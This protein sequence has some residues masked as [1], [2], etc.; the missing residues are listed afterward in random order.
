VGGV[1]LG[2]IIYH[3]CHTGGLYILRDARLL[4]SPPAAFNDPF[5]LSPKYVRIEPLTDEWGAEMLGEHFDEYYERI[6]RFHGRSKEEER[7]YCFTNM[8]KIVEELRAK[9]PE[10]ANNI[11]EDFLQHSSNIWTLGCFSKTARSVLMWSHYAKKHT[12]MVIGFDTNHKPFNMPGFLDLIHVKYRKERPIFIHGRSMETFEKSLRRV[13][14]TKSK[15]WSYEREVRVLVPRSAL[16]EGKY[17]DLIAPSVVCVIYA[18]NCPPLF[19]MQAYHFLRQPLL[20]HVAIYAARLHKTDYKL[21]FLMLRK[22][23]QKFGI[24]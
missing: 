16:D 24:R 10:N 2:V 13:V 20:S 23:S 6:G 9:S 1:K 17:M 4:L 18:S 12:G 19:R 14:G 21:E 8:D 3:Y 22:G 5:E 7:K 15:D 11:K